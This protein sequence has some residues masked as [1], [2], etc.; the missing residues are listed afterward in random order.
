MTQFIAKI[1]QNYH[2]L[3]LQSQAVK[4][5]AK[6]KSPVDDYKINHM[7][8]IIL[9]IQGMQYQKV[10][11]QKKYSGSKR[12]FYTNNNK[13]ELPTL[14]KLVYEKIENFNQPQEKTEKLSGEKTKRRTL[15]AGRESTKLHKTNYSCALFECS[16]REN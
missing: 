6:F 10:Y 1:S 5:R 16:R 9:E 14:S 12:P 7:G 3:E 13:K 4:Q 15:G 8:K 11:D 2:K